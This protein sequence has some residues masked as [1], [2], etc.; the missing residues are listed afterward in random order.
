V[1]MITIVGCGPGARQCLTLEALEAAASAEVL[2][3]SPRLLDLF[4]EATGERIAVRGSLAEVE[5]A[6]SVHANRRIAVLVTGDPGIAS[7]SRLVLRRFGKEA[8]RV[9]PGVSSV[10]TAFARLGADWTGARIVSAHCAVPETPYPALEG[11]TAIAILLGSPGAAHWS[12]GLAEH[13]GEGWALFLAENL[14]FPGETVEAITPEALRNVAGDALRIAIL[15]R[16]D[17]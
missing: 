6:V 5:A 1:E 3:G 16:R 17:Q 13:L 15:L 10:Q 4:P 2:I 12:A 11:E 7:L 14:T 9:I 8:C